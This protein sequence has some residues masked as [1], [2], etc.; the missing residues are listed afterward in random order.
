MKRL[1]K[2]QPDGSWTADSEAAAA[3]RLAQYESMHEALEAE[4]TKICADMDR[5][6]SSGRTKS[7]TYRQLLVNKLEVRNLLDR[8]GLYVK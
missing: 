4:F 7:A 8:I 5:L 6:R 1:T 3:E 2:K